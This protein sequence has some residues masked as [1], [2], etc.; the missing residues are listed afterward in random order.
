M[1]RV[2]S[3]LHRLLEDKQFRTLDEAQDYMSSMTPEQMYEMV[4]TESP[5]TPADAGWLN[6][7]K[8]CATR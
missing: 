4:T 6:G 2:L 8:G 5:R 7:T 3:N 1:E